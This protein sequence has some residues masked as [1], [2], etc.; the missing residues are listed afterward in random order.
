MPPPDALTVTVE[1]ALAVVD[2]ALSVSVLL[3]VPGD[4][5]EA[6]EK[7]A[8]TPFGNPL[9]EN[10]IDAPKPLVPTAYT[11]IGSE[12]P[13]GT[14]TLVPPRE[15]LKLGPMTVSVTVKVL[16]IPPPEPVIV[17]A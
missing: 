13:R 3:P 16:E 5:I 2:A 6:G 11:E 4:A 1:V 15:R 10:R 14:V 9:M 7:V 8:V 17:N 12:P